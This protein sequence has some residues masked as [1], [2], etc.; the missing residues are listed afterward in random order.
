[1]IKLLHIMVSQQHIENDHRSTSPAHVEI[2][3]KK[4]GEELTAAGVPGSSSFLKSQHENATER[5]SFKKLSYF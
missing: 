1:M 5:L 4:P 3:V 2:R